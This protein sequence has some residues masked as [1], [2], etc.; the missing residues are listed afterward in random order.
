MIAAVNAVVHKNM[1]PK[2]AYDMFSSLKA[3]GLMRV[4]PGCVR[5]AAEWDGKR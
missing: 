2:E 3:K 5:G 4:V 1:K